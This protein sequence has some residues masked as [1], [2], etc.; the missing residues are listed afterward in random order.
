MLVASTEQA[1]ELATR[2]AGWEVMDAAPSKTKGNNDVAGEDTAAFGTIITET[3]AGK[4]GLYAD[5]LIREAEI[6]AVLR[7]KDSPAHG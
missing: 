1:R 2:L 5:V 4:D 3:K 6:S 7:F